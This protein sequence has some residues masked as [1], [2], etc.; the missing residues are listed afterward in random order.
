[1]IYVCEPCGTACFCQPQDIEMSNVYP[2]C[3]SC[4]QDMTPEDEL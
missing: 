1:M 2:T 4:E 3:H